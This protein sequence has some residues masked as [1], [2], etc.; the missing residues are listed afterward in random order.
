MGYAYPV[1]DIYVPCSWSCH[2]NRNPP[3]TEAGTDYASSYGTPVYAP[4]DGTVAWIHN[5]YSGASGK[6]VLI[7]T[8]DGRS[9]DLMHLDRIEVIAG[10]KVKKGKSVIGYS[11]ASGYG[12]PYYYG[13]HCHVSQFNKPNGAPGS[14]PTV[15]F[16]KYVG[17]DPAPAP[18]KLEDDD[19]YRA[20]STKTGTWYVIGELSVTQIES[21]AK[22]SANWNRAVA[23]NDALDGKSFPEMSSDAIKSLLSDVDLRVS[24]FLTRIGNTVAAASA[25][26]DIQA[27]IA[28]EDA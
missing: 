9:H 20:K 15:D 23:Y 14:D 24:D 4:A 26:A 16:E 11:G 21:G 3:S 27:M 19:M 5:S 28:K 25:S 2:T 12:D 1:G 8:N 6:R 17:A 22:G 18:P 10:Q 13:P 7:N